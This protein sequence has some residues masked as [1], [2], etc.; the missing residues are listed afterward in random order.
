MKKLISHFL[1][2]VTTSTTLLLGFAELFLLNIQLD[3]VLKAE[4]NDLA[5]KYT[6]LSTQ[7]ETLGKKTSGKALGVFAGGISSASSYTVEQDADRVK[8]AF[9]LGQFDNS[10]YVP[11]DGL[12]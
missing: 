1:S 7:I 11:T 3:G 6:S 2:R 10:N 4:Y 5:S 12:G 8:P 9:V